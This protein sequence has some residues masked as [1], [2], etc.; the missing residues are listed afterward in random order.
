MSESKAVKSV[1]GKERETVL[2]IINL[3]KSFKGKEVLKDT[4]LTLFKGE[5]LVVLGKSGTGK[6]VLIKCIVGLLRPDK[7]SVKVFGREISQMKKNEL[8]EIRQRIGFLFQN[9]ALYDSMTVK[10]NLVFPLVRIKKGIKKEEV[11]ERVKAV[12]ESIGLPEVMNKMPSELSG[13]MR[14][15]VSLARTIIVDPEIML[16]DEPTTGLDPVT[17]DEIS[18]LINE[19]QEKY[20]TS[21]IIITHDLRCAMKTGD[22]MIMLHEGVVHSEGSLE[23]FKES[24]DPLIK[25]FF[26]ETS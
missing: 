10:Q 6:S 19:V 21:S 16:Y 24:E 26:T 9:G 14:K 7:G 23:E 13:G 15:R 18:E 11:E 20:H 25:S 8:T 3:N 17:S 12:L 1:D 4:N 2:E 22:R 5:N